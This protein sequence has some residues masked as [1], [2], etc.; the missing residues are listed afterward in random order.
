MK[1]LAVIVL[2]FFMGGASLAEAHAFVDHAEPRVGSTV[3]ASPSIVKIWFTDGLRES[4]SKIEV[5]DVK[6][7]KVDKGDVKIDPSDKSIMFVSVPKLSGGSYKVVWNAV[8]PLGHHTSGSFT[9]E[10]KN[11]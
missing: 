7:Q 10:V 2:S 11:P 6:G 5:F 8:C 3:E 1:R 4:V 9:F